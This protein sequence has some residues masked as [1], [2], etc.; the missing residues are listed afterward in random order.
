ML[1]TPNASKSAA[2]RERLA[3]PGGASQEA[4]SGSFT[5]CTTLAT[6]LTLKTMTEFLT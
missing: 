1:N 2:I 5:L 3:E 6:R 4:A